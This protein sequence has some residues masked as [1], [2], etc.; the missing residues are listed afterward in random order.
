MGGALSDIANA[1]Q[2]AIVDSG[3]QPELLLYVAFLATFAFIRTSTHMIR[4]GVSWWPGN[5][6][7]KGGTHVHHMVFGILA[8]LV[9]GFCSLSLD[10][11][12][13]WR[14]VLAVLFGIGAGLTLDEFALW[15]HLEDVYWAPKGRQSIDAVIVASVLGGLV[16]LGVRV[17]VDLGKEV[18][19]VVAAAGILGAL[20]AALNV[21]KGKLVMAV[22]S[23]LVPVVGT[24]G[25]AR[26]AR[27]DSPWARLYG[28]PKRER[29]RERFPEPWLP[30]RSSRR[31]RRASES[32]RR[33]VGDRSPRG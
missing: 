7:T 31:L 23:L 26:L 17:W 28:E 12:T 19:A 13:P 22:A 21:V 3:K 8:L 2:Q 6:S 9:V 5:V 4:A 16:L 11:D 33:P 15:L 14:E 29:A 30:A 32:R 10:P 20:V 18:E 1:Y 25:V 24:V 27:P